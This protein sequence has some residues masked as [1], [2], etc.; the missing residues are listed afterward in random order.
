[1]TRLQQLRA[2]FILYTA[3]LT[4]LSLRPGGDISTPGQTDKIAHF[5]AYAGLAFLALLTFRSNTSR[6]AALIFVIALGVF[7]EWVQLYIDGRTASFLDAAVN[8]L[9]VAGG[10]LLYYFRGRRLEKHIG[11]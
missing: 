3:I 7:L 10:V 8:F 2:L 5:L 6:A 11:P 9:G 4:A 1:M